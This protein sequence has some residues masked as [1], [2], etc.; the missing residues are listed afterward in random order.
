[1]VR[2]GVRVRVKIRVKVR[3]RVRVRVRA[4][5]R[6]RVRVRVRARVR[7]RR[8]VRTKA[9]RLDG[10]CH[11]SSALSFPSATRSSTRLGCIADS[12]HVRESRPS[13]L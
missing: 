9:G 12:F 7:R 4:R 5:V 10:A 3:V 11:N 13:K 8:R 6:V 1:M 2:V